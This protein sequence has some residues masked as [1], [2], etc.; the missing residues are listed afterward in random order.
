MVNTRNKDY[1]EILGNEQ[2]VIPVE[3][4]VERRQRWSSLLQHQHYQPIIDEVLDEELPKYGQSSM[5]NV[6]DRVSHMRECALI[7]ASAPSVFAAAVDG[8]LVRDMLRNTDLQKDYATIQAQ[9]HHQP[10][11]YIHLLADEGGIAP[12]QT[13]TCRSAP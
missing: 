1:S 10:S 2:L 5:I 6:Q 7:L 13:S 8:T 3:T 11:I 12:T 4:L 9:A